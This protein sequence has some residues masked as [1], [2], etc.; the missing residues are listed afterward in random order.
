MPE[1]FQYLE[2][3]KKNLACIVRTLEI[4]I[5]VSLA[6]GVH[7]SLQTPGDGWKG[8]HRLQYHSLAIIEGADLVNDF[9]LA[10]GASLGHD[11]DLP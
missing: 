8:G 5:P 1:I 4:K 10:Y 9:E 2:E 7:V 6:F 3:E 11:S